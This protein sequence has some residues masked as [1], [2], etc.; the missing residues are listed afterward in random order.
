MDEARV[1][2]IAELLGG[3]DIV[4]TVLDGTPRSKARPRLGK[5]G[6][7]KPDAAAEE[8]TAWLLRSQLRSRWDGPVVLVCEFFRPDR[9]RVDADNLLKHVCDA[10]NLARIWRDD[11]QVEVIVGWVHYA[12]A[13]P[14]TVLALGSFTGAMARVDAGFARESV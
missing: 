7:Y 10:G 1:R 2:T 14:R 5:H 8:A 9:R 12:E 3:T 4:T 6:T 13:R 11:S